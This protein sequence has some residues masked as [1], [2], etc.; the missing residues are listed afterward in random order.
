MPCCNYATDGN[1]QEHPET[2]ESETNLK[3]IVENVDV[4]IYL[5]RKKHCI[6]HS[7]IIIKKILPLLLRAAAIEAA[8]LACDLTL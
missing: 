3:R 7:D 8:L 4:H 1:G 6:K 5:K 2:V